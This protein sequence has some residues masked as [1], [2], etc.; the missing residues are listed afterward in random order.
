M[1]DILKW[2]STYSLPIVFLIILGAVFIYFV[3]MVTEKVI[4]NE[5]DRYK[6]VIE[7][8]L[9]RRSSFEEKILLDRYFI[10]RELQTKIGNVMTNLNRIRHGGKVDG[11]IVN[12]DIVPLT[13]IFE[14][15][16]VN[17]YLITKKFHEIFWQQSQ[18][19][20]GFANQKDELLLKQLETKYIELL[21]EFYKEIN[22]MFDLEKIKW[23]V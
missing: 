7:L 18:I 16:A 19:A 17:K 8:E 4:S 3:K 9:Q 5:F 20:I 1:E 10:I 15:L 14:L 2:L 22:E 23:K 12:N 21:E 6:K 11:F 13:E